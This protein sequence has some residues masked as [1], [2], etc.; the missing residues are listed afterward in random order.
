M[1]AN[2]NPIIPEIDCSKLTHYAPLPW[3][4]WNALAAGGGGFDAVDWP[5]VPW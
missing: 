1:W 3:L 5:T 4:A 2:E